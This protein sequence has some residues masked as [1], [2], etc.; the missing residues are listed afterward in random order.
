MGLL[1][2]KLGGQMVFGEDLIEKKEQKLIFLQL[3]QYSAFGYRP[4]DNIS[5]IALIH[6]LA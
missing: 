4:Y 2:K 1:T 3:S 6:Y 5:N